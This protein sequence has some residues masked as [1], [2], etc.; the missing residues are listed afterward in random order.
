MVQELNRRSDKMISFVGFYGQL[1]TDGSF[2]G[3]LAFLAMPWLC[4]LP[5]C[6]YNYVRVAFPTGTKRGYATTQERE[7]ND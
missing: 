6:I 4:P 5:A 3:S 2:A 1:L 7:H